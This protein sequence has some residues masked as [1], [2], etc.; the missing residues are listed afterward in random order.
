MTPPQTLGA[1]LAP[2]PS[3][4]PAADAAP[5][6]L[7]ASV[8]QTLTA[9]WLA[10]GHKI[11][12]PEAFAASVARSLS[13]ELRSTSRSGAGEAHRIEVT[14]I[15]RGGLDTP[16]EPQQA[17]GVLPESDHPEQAADGPRYFRG[18]VSGLIT[19][20]LS[21]EVARRFAAMPAWAEVQILPARNVAPDAPRYFRHALSGEVELVLDASDAPAYQAAIGYTEV[22][23]LPL[24]TASRVGAI[25]SYLDATRATPAVAR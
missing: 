4:I 22:Q 16:A 2:T 3:P 7:A 23:P 1:Q 20:A 18:V 6:A 12:H 21:E 19:Q 15:V 17:E 9:H 25:T 14:A 24:D 8:L 5:S 10:T 13:P 11:E